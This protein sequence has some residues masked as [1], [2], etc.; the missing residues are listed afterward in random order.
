MKRNKSAEDYLESILLLS[1]ENEA[2][3]RVDIARRVGV[4][5]PAVQ[6]AIK[7]LLD[8][9]YVECSGMHIQLTR[10]GREYAERI[11]DRHVTLRRFLTSLGVDEKTADADACE[12]E[13]VLSERSFEAMKNSLK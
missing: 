11:Y 8:A 12:M 2:V 9:G 6:K 1:R 7:L 13:H 4:S 5:S 10:S 3:H